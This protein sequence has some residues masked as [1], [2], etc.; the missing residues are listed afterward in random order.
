MGATGW[1]RVELAASELDREALSKT[2]GHMFENSSLVT[3]TL[4]VYCCIYSHL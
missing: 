3:Y 4:A 1:P 2:V